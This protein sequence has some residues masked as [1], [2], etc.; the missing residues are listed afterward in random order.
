MRKKTV[1]LLASIG[2]FLL[3]ASLVFGFRVLIKT[4]NKDF[5][6]DMDFYKA[7]GNYLVKQG[8]YD[9]AVVAYETALSLGEDREV[10]N[11]LAVIYYNQ[12]RYDEA[13]AKLRRLIT[14]DENNPSYHYDL[15]VNLVEKF[16]TG[17]EYNI[18]NL[19]E[20]LEEYILAE[21]LSP[22]YAYAEENIAVLKRIIG[23]QNN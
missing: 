19:I 8:R 4:E 20:A 6:E 22:G 18:N 10:L 5:K 3:L 17:D 21:Q 9:D 13:I 2:A 14:L 12:G 11:N 16:R 15:A 1:I 23:I 7:L